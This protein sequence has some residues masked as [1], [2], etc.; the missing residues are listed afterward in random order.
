MFGVPLIADFSEVQDS[1][2]IGAAADLEWYLRF[3]LNHDLS[4]EDQQMDDFDTEIAD[5]YLC[6]RSV[7]KHLDYL[8]GLVASCLIH[9]MRLA[10]HEWGVLP[11]DKPILF[12][13]IHHAALTEHIISYLETKLTGLYFMCHYDFPGVFMDEEDHALLML[14]RQLCRHPMCKGMSLDTDGKMNKRAISYDRLSSRSICR[15]GEDELA[16]AG[17]LIAIDLVSMLRSFLAVSTGEE[18]ISA[19]Q[20]KELMQRMRPLEDRLRI[21][22][23]DTESL[24]SME[25]AI[26][27]M[28]IHTRLSGQDSADELDSDNDSH[29]EY[30]KRSDEEQQEKLNAQYRHAEV[31]IVDLGNACWTHKHFTEDIQTRQYRSPEVLIGANYDTSSDMWSLGCIVFE[32]LTGDLMFDPHSGKTWNREEDHLALIIELLGE[33]PRSLLAEG[34]RSG[35]Y[36]NRNGE[37]RHIQSLNFWG[38]KDVLHEKYKFTLADAV[39]I[40]DFL[41]QVMTV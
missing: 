40:A 8:S 10:R 30:K 3:R 16:G 20:I 28:F 32:L 21:F 23:S 18:L 25:Y 33:F 14:S 26:R 1:D 13:L 12:E 19:K 7:G 34:K 37:L 22:V 24:V 5:T 2:T 39:G 31:S 27:K 15:D 17:A 4:D 6:I 41:E 29:W 11:D 38:L 36:F 9:P 35:E